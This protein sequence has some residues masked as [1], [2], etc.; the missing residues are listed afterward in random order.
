MQ[1]WGP[2]V[3]AV[4]LATIAAVITGISVSGKKTSKSELAVA[5]G[6][7]GPYR[8]YDARPTKDLYDRLGETVQALR[9]AANDK[10]W[11]IDWRRVDELQKQGAEHLN[12]NDAKNAVRHQSE[13]IIETMNQLREQHNRAAGET[14]AEE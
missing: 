11:M 10:N 8:R 2:T 14:R 3:V 1:S 4:V 12:A 5:S 9:D 7:K 13:A 6:G